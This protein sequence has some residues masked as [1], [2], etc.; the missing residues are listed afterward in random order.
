MSYNITGRIGALTAMLGGLDMI[1]FASA[2]DGHAPE[3]RVRPC[4][5][6]NWPGP[7]LSREQATG[8]DGSAA[9]VGAAPAREQPTV[10]R[11]SFAPTRPAAR[12]AGATS[13]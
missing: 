2:I 1:V 4:G 11:H 6:C 9:R 7:R 3:F 8:L 13:R 5:R 12:K 10:A